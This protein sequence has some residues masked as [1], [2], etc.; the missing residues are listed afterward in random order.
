MPPRRHRRLRSAFAGS[1][2]WLVDGAYR[3]TSPEQR[4]HSRDEVE[5]T[6]GRKEHRG[7]SGRSSPSRTN[8]A[9]D[10]VRRRLQL[11][12]SR[13]V[14]RPRPLSPK[15]YVQICR[16]SAAASAGEHAGGLGWHRRLLNGCQF[17]YGRLLSCMNT[18]LLPKLPCNIGGRDMQ[19]RPPTGFIAMLMQF[20]MMFT[21]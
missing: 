3:K 8:A 7:S 14:C 17:G 5:L 19:V 18:T 16:S 4:R 6:G 15:F 13:A 9:A 12:Q 11:G 20:M 10:R 1:W 21:A 2:S